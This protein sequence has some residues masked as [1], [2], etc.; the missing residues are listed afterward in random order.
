QPEQIG[1]ALLL[2]QSF[3]T[4]RHQLT[5]VGRDQRGWIVAGVAPRP[6]PV[7]GWRSLVQVGIDGRGKIGL[8]CCR[9]VAD[10]VTPSLRQT[11]LTKIL[12]R[13]KA[14][15]IWVRPVVMHGR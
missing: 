14:A 12:S 2:R 7:S 1:P 5:L 11:G 13:C 3:V 8:H 4:H 15:G 6:I 10:S 9:W